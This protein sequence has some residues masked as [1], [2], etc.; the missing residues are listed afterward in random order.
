MSKK[1]LDFDA[2]N[3]AAEK[4]KIESANTDSEID[5]ATIKAKNFKYPEFWEKELF[6]KQVKDKTYSGT[7][8]NFIKEAVRQK[9]LDSGIDIEN[10]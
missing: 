7:W 2:I 4:T 9:L 10:M 6:E 8:Q 1:D 3:S 5:K